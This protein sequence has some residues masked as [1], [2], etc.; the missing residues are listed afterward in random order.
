MLMMA[1]NDPKNRRAPPR[2]GDEAGTALRLIREMVGGR[3]KRRDG[4]PKPSRGG[5]KGEKERRQ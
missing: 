2:G 3:G 1:V 4:W 5:R